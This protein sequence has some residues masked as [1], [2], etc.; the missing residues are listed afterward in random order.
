MKKQINKKEFIGK[1]YGKITI[2]DYLGKIKENS[3]DN[4]R[5]WLGK[6]E[7][8]K[9]IYLRQNDILKEIRKSCKKCNKNSYKHGM[10]NSRLFHI[11]QNMIGR[12]YCK[13]NPD[14]KNYGARNIK[15]C[16]E[17]KNDL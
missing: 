11:W 3:G 5:F 4:H 7:C 12:C 15:I 2:I 14:Y 1:K 9:S 13:T 16:K 17:W 6:C 8:G 10:T